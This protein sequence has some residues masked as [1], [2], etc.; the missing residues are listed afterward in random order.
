M[1]L[2]QNVFRPFTPIMKQVPILFGVGLFKSFPRLAVS[3]SQSVDD[4]G[5]RFE[6]LVACLAFP[7]Y[8]LR[9]QALFHGPPVDGFQCGLLDLLQEWQK[10]FHAPR[11]LF[12]RRFLEQFCVCFEEHIAVSP[13]CQFI[14]G[15]FDPLVGTAIGI[16][17]N[18]RTYQLLTGSKDLQDDAYPVHG[19][20]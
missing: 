11:C 4:G 13:P 19:I 6:S 9:I 7:E 17:V 3:E 15:G 14:R 20:L 1:Q 2:K 5:F 12:S 18:K 10:G 8:R 16:G